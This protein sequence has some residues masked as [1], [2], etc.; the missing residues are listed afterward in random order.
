VPGVIGLALNARAVHT[1]SQ[2]ADSANTQVL[3]SW[4]RFDIGGRYTFDVGSKVITLRAAIDNVAN[5]NYWASA[6]GYPGY[7]YLVEGA[8]RS[9]RMSGTVAF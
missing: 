1:G 6:G 3:P 7:G 4:N 9:L 5:R 2:Y 8:T